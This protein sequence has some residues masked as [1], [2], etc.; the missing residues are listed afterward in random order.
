M[1]RE[2]R[3]NAVKEGSRA[4]LQMIPPR[5]KKPAC[6]LPRSGEHAFLVF[7]WLSEAG[8]QKGSRHARTSGGRSQIDAGPSV[9]CP[10][11]QQ[12]AKLESERF[13]V[14]LSSI[15]ASERKENV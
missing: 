8:K 5:R 6:V 12:P 9:A 13:L 7:N 14:Q 10:Q 1:H 15:Q 4:L 2:L 11:F 3:A